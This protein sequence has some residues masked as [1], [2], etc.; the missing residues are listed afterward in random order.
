[1]FPVGVHESVCER[2]PEQRPRTAVKVRGMQQPLRDETGPLQDGIAAKFVEDECADR[3]QHHKKAAE[4]EDRRRQ[5]EGRRAFGRLGKR[6]PVMVCRPLPA[7][8]I[9]LAHGRPGHGHNPV[10][11][12]THFGP[13]IALSALCPFLARFS[14]KAGG[15][16]L[17]SSLRGTRNRQSDKVFGVVW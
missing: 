2:R 12:A 11:Q 14:T 9:R 5:V 6:A 8:R 17:N 10:E 16:N 13:S 1:M 3:L 7:R 15:V 4:P